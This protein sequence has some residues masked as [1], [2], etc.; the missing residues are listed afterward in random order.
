[1][2]M[3][4]CSH[5]AL[6]DRAEFVLCNDGSCW[7]YTPTPTPAD[8]SNWEWVEEKPIPGTMRA[9]AYDEAVTAI[10]SSL[11]QGADVGGVTP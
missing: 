1:M 9:A 3:P 10:R 8:S 7:R 4:V 2:R 11:L 5:V 6:E